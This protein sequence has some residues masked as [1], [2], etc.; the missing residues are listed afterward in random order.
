M[1]TLNKYD[2]FAHFSC[3]FLILLKNRFFTN[4]NGLIVLRF[5]RFPL[6]ISSPWWKLWQSRFTMFKMAN[7]LGLVTREV[8]YNDIR[9]KF[10]DVSTNSQSEAFLGATRSCLGELLDLQS[11]D[12]SDSQKSKFEDQIW[13]FTSKVSTWMRMKKSKANMIK[14]KRRWFDEMIS[15]GEPDSKE[16]DSKIP[17]V[18]YE[19]ASKTTQHRRKRK[20][21]NE[22]GA[23]ALS[24]S[25]AMSLH[26]QGLSANAQVI[27]KLDKNPELGPQLLAAL[28]N[29]EKG[30]TNES[31]LP[32]LCVPTIKY[33]ANVL[34]LY[35]RGSN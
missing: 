27:R 24:G 17:L 22:I 10:P 28:K 26:D 30:D 2:I 16:P 3:G 14:W 5:G 29:I 23:A 19:N 8:L 32:K 9:Q 11:D 7:S 13:N 34:G 6:R 21:V 20:H 25:L 4:Q 1:Q 12:L 31:V 35:T 33:A 15:L 18:S